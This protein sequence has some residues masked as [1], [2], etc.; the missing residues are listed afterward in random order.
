MEAEI[1]LM[2]PQ[3]MESQDCPFRNKK[4]ARKNPFLANNLVLE[5]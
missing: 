2:L 3:D 4:E 1:G 5:F